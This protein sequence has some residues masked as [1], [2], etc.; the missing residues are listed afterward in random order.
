MC[1]IVGVASADGVAPDAAALDAMRDRMRHR[2][3]DDAGSW[4]S[5]D[6]CVAL[7]HRRLSILDLSP[8]GHQPMLRDGGRL[9]LTFN[10]EVYNFRE[11]RDELAG[12]G[13]RF[14]TG[15]DTE[16]V[17]AA[18]R[19]WGEGC[20]ARLEGMFA[21]AL[22]DAD[23]RRLL[24]ARDRAGE[25][26]LFYR[27]AGGRL[28]FASELKALLADPAFPREL[29]RGALEFYLAYGY[30]PGER[31]ILRGAA[32][33]PAGCAAVYDLE[34]DALRVWRYWELPAPYRGPRGDA[35]ALAGELEALL[36]ASVRR[37]L[38][39]DVPVGILLSGGLDSSVVTALAA[40]VSERPVKTFTVTFPGHGAYDEAPFA[41]QV[42]EHHGT[43]HTELPMEPA[44]VELLPE[45]ARQYDEPMA[46]SSMVPTYLV[47]R[48]V[49]RHCTVALG[50]DGGDELF[51]GYPHY[52]WI[53]R[54]QAVRRVA[55]RP[56]RSLVG[57]A[58]GALPVGV[59]GR[60]HLL[61][62]AA[63]TRASVAAVN[64]YFDAATRR[65]LV[66]DGANGLPSPEGWK[67]ALCDHGRTPLQM[68][69]AADFL[70]YLTD[71]ILVKVDRASMLTSLEV[72]A[73]LLDRRVVEFAFGRLDDSLRATAQARKVILR[74]LGR[75]LLPPA[76]DL[77]RKQGLSVPLSAWFKGRWGS[78]M[79][80]VLL[81]PAQTLFD[82][83][84]VR[85]LVAGQ[86]R[87]LNNTHRLYALTL[88]ELWRREYGVAA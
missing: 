51:G 62:F 6:A 1:G 35:G 38:V 53:L 81:D 20:V 46:D 88:F 55:P 2:G 69:T 40:R 71:D 30:V 19:R 49:R 4:R 77:T 66:P 22:Y 45:L 76:L 17:L 12:A 75:R 43:E 61:A 52:N 3:P 10:G 83:G 13:E 56:L 42:A 33:L 78:Y 31:C 7:A 68:A 9:A 65:A 8:A 82:Q 60:N 28:A 34:R 50:G 67:R 11:L 80:S 70:G 59:R 41:R 14:A 24:L 74:R 63:D 25:K 84:V 86:R 36:E 73:P 87:G 27:H 37:Q 29:D 47:S 54:Q 57:A 48:L 26:P 44:T 23:A 39:A 16:V 32:K 79:E 15:T 18:Y 72:R 85:T 58:A 21:L 64:L 5:A